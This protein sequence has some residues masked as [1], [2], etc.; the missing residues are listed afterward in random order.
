MMKSIEKM[1]QPKATGQNKLYSSFVCFVIFICYVF[2]HS[3]IAQ[4]PPTQQQN[5][6]RQEKKPKFEKISSHIIVVTISGLRADDINNLGNNRLRVETIRSLLEKGSHAVS[7]ESIYPSL[8]NP[9]HVTIATGTLPADH[10]IT[11][12]FPFNEQSAQQSPE[13]YFQSKEIKND[14]IWDAAKRGGFI[15]A[16]IG[17]PMTSGATI[18]FNLPTTHDE[19]LSA[20][21]DFPVEEM[22]SKQYVNPPELSQTLLSLQKNV[23]FL[24]NKKLK[25]IANHQRL[26]YFKA[27][28]AAFLIENHRPNLLMINFSSFARAEEKYGLQSRESFLALESVDGLLKKIVDSVE[29]AQLSQET[30]LIVASDYGSMRVE[31][32]FN[33][34]H[35]L[36]KKGWLSIDSQERITSWQAVAQS[37]GGSAAIFVKNPQDEKT[38]REIEKLFNEYHERPDSPIWRIILRREASQLGADP[39]VFFYLDAAP[40]YAMTSR[41]NVSTISKSSERVAHGYLPS[42]SEA[43]ATL[44]ISGKGIKDGARIEYARLIDIAPTI[45]RLFGLEMRTARGRILSEVITP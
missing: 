3:L 23:S 33:P 28:A 27:T 7:V 20:E 24:T 25:Q 35:L 30:T 11:S 12:D 31:H 29:N 43:R 45:A 16:A 21:S 41:A 37:F 39:R 14:T 2:S 10:G 32:L 13:P 42:R 18:N 1:R 6:Q 4:N 17:F 15:T 26:D 40:L 5:Q 36:A 22:F 9:A 44:I 8:T 19:K 38:I 34:N